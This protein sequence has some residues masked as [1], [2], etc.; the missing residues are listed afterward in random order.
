MSGSEDYVSK[1]PASPS[2]AAEHELEIDLRDPVIA[3][4]L[5]W[6]VPGLGH[7]YQRRYAKAV[8]FSVCILG[9]FLFGLYLGSD[10]EIGWGR[11][12]YMSWRPLDKRYAYLA[13]AFVGAPAFPAILQA[14]RVKNGKP[15]VLNEL[16]APPPLHP[17]GRG[18]DIDAIHR[19]L[20][21]YF[22]LGTVYTMIAGLLNILA[23][24][25]AWAGPV[26]PEPEEEGEGNPRGKEEDEDESGTKEAP[27]RKA[28]G[29]DGADASA[30][31]R[32]SGD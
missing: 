1:Q 3:A 26:F 31:V 20:G 10:P 30:A 2:K 7:F 6:L 15:P 8:L 12:V 16:M 21:R 13:Q 4:F 23:I 22:E 32:E 17:G 9:T 18:V 28:E 24:F 19:R 14:V 29:S 5:A 27:S 25:D 11:V